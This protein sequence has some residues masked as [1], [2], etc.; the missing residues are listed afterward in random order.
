MTKESL[1]IL[2]GGLGTRAKELTNGAHK[3]LIKL[4]DGLS[5]IERLL[6]QAKT[7]NVER[8][9][10]VSDRSQN[11]GVFEEVFGIASQKN[12]ET[13]SINQDVDKFYGT[14]FALALICSSVPED[15]NVIMFEGD[16]VVSDIA[17][18]KIFATI[19]NTFIIDDVPKDDCESMKVVISGG[20]IKKFSKQLV[21]YP[22]FCGITHLDRKIRR[23]YNVV[24][25]KVKTK[26]PYYE[27]VFNR[28][29]GLGVELPFSSI[30][31]S[32][33]NEVDDMNDYI[34]TKDKFSSW[35]VI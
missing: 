22:E 1:A 24:A 35:N 9:Y 25:K 2:A 15:E 19:P 3:S 34:E 12:I 11:T 13:I 29:A 33:W 14:M 20:K 23:T 32:E 18:T 5:I 10:L 17:A 16:V 30:A 28:L 7:N 6:S 4:P 27:E 31:E 8:V 21:G 26:N